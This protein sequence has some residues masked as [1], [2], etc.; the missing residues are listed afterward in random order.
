MLNHHITCNNCE[1]RPHLRRGNR[2]CAAMC[3]TKPFDILMMS[4]TRMLLMIKRM[5]AMKMLIVVVEINFT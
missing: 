5:I 4:M 3:Q 1:L 2:D